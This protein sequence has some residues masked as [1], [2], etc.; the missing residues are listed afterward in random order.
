MAPS[1]R[2][3]WALSFGSSTQVWRRPGGARYRSPGSVEAGPSRG[4]RERSGLP[5]PTRPSALQRPTPPGDR[6]L[7]SPDPSR[8]PF[9]APLHLIRLL[10]DVAGR[11]GAELL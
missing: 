1:R 7:D 10:P 2:S 11:L 4:E 5:P 3:P 6:L 9:P 8:A